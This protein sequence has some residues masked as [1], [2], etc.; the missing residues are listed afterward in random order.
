MDAG[1]VAWL[2][3]DQPSARGVPQLSRCGQSTG[4]THFGDGEPCHKVQLPGR[5]RFVDRATFEVR[6]D[7][8]GGRGGPFGPG[9]ATSVLPYLE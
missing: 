9:R 7:L 3:V 1:W 6:H 4:A 8:A 5:H 2:F